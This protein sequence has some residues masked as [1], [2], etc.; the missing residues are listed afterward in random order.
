MQRVGEAGAGVLGVH[1]HARLGAIADAAARRVEDAPHADRV[2]GIVQHPQVGDDVANLFALVK[3]HSPNDFVRNAG[4][5]EH[6]F[7]RPRRV[8]SAIEDG[9]IVVGDVAAV[10]ERIDLFGHEPGLVVLVVGDVADDQLPLAGVGPQP[11]SRRPELREITELAADRMF[12]V[13]R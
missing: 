1:R 12:C 11:L 3:A 13:E 6:L 8:V 10:G 7:Q 4:A 9:H 2:A 5:D